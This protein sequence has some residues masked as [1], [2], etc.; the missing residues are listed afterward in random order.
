MFL[1]SNTSGTPLSLIAAHFFCGFISI[2]IAGVLLLITGPDLAGHYFQPH[3]LAITHLVVLGWITTIIFGVSYQLIPVLANKKLYSLGLAKATLALLTAGTAIM[4]FSFFNFRLDAL[5]FTGGF[6]VLVSFL[7]YTFNIY[8]TWG[9]G[10][11][12]SEAK[13]FVFISLL[14]LCITA[15]FGVVLLFNLRLAFLSISH[16]EMLKLHAHFGCVGWLLFLVMGIASKLL[17]MFMLSEGYN[18]KLLKFSLYSMNAGLLILI[19]LIVNGSSAWLFLPAVILC[20]GIVSYLLFVKQV[21]KRRVRK[22]LDEGLR[23]SRLAFVLLF[24]PVIAGL[25]LAANK[26]ENASLNQQ[27]TVFY[28]FSFLF[29]FVTLLVMAQTFKTLPFLVWS[30]YYAASQAQH[31][32]LPKDLYSENLM[33]IQFI[34][35]MLS[36]VVFIAALASGL[37]LAFKAGAIM[38][39]ASV[40]FYGINLS[41]LLLIHNGRAPGR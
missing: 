28:G 34:L 10:E 20:A 17:P 3:L 33:K 36:Y 22:I 37:P 1:Q 4:S 18:K 12:Q 14:W 32:L 21:L 6:L 23:K 2:L 24:A 38:F 25:W 11:E 27:V 19:G 26:N 5:A 13:D 31:R 40:V 41:R 29:G 39:L 9:A 8:K 15:V 7:C 16:L 35:F 30:K